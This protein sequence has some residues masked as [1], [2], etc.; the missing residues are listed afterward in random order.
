VCLEAGKRPPDAK[1]KTENRGE[2]GANGENIRAM[3]EISGELGVF[4][5][6]VKP[7]VYFVELAARLKPCPDASCGPKEVFPQ[8]V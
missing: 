5:Q 4:P 7:I 6:P 2:T 8:P 1:T 3:D